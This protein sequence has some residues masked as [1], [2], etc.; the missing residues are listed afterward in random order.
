MEY[1]F[2]LNT[3][4][5]VVRRWS[6]HKNDGSHIIEALDPFTA[7]ITLAAHIEHAENEGGYWN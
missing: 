2:F 7:L 1:F 4:N 3:T 6:A 5:Q